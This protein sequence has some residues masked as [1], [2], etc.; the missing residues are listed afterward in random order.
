MHYV[1]ELLHLRYSSILLKQ[2]LIHVGT[3]IVVI[4]DIPIING[5]LHYFL[6]LIGKGF[7]WQ[8]VYVD[9]F[10]HDEVF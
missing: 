3:L 2:E 10:V 4:C 6:V 1:I 5:S 7:F 8:V 9:C